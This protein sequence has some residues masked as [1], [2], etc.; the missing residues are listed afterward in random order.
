MLRRIAQLILDFRLTILMVLAVGTI[1]MANKSRE[2]KIVYEFA[3]LLPEND[4]ASISYDHFKERFGLDGNILL[5]SI[6]DSN[7]F[8]LAHFQDWYSLSDRIKKIKG[9]QEV[10]SVARVYNLIKDDSLEKFRFS[11]VLNVCPTLQNQVDSVR[12]IVLH[13]PFYDGFLFNSKDKATVLAVTFDKK[14]LNT[15]RRVQ[16][17]D[18]IQVL[19][20]QYG[21]KYN[22][23]V[24]YSGLPYIRTVLQ[25][26]VSREMI[27]FLG[28][29]FGVTILI[30][31][32]F[33]LS[34]RYSSDRPPDIPI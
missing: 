11:P 27:L 1:F 22:L 4:S 34:P 12:E 20:N 24:H 2:T 13:L 26:L 15:K 17:T 31:F 28:L 10:V 32:L 33:F 30:L 19:A 16:I 6:Q 29:A 7:I 25:R 3:K 5:L 23:K 8:Q 9:I 18:T 21:Q 14:D